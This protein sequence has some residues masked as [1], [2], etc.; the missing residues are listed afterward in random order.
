[1]AV[2]G[3]HCADTRGWG[4]RFGANFLGSFEKL[5]PTELLDRRK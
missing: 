1:M 3:A 4:N 2:R 5:G